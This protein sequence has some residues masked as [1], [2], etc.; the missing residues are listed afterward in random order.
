MDIDKPV[1]EYGNAQAVKAD[2]ASMGE[3][4]ARHYYADGTLKPYA[5]AL[6][7]VEVYRLG[8]SRL[9]LSP[10]LEGEYKLTYIVGKKTREYFGSLAEI[11]KTRDAI[12]SA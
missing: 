1:W 2:K 6:G 7:Y 3:D 11:R 12:L 8:S 9:M 10:G 4:F 5:F